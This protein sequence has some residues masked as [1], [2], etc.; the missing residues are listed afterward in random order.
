LC[1][2][3]SCG[4]YVYVYKAGKKYTLMNSALLVF[5]AVLITSLTTSFFIHNTL[6]ES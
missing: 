5:Y 6:I 4:I 1:F 2:G 3:F